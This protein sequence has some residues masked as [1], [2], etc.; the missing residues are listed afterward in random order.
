M[1]KEAMKL[2]CV[3]ESNVNGKKKVQTH[4]YGVKKDAQETGLLKLAENIDKLTKNL[5]TKAK[6]VEI[7]VLR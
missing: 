2:S 3:Y 1:E 7:S 6:V 5:M 4:S